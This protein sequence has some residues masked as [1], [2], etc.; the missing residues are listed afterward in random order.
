MTNKAD[1]LFEHEITLEGQ[2]ITYSYD[3]EGDILEIFFRKGGG[4][5]I[6]LTENIVLRYNQEDQKPLSLILTDFSRLTRLT[7][8]G[9]PSFRLTSLTT[10]PP[11]M[12]RTVLQMLNSFPVNHFLK[13]SGLALSPGGELQPITYLEQPTSLPL[14]TVRI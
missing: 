8:F 2:I 10:L 7:K 13:V 9:P 14:N 12:Q 6:D 5:G 3:K 1:W 11:N 4:L